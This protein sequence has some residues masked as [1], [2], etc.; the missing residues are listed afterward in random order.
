MDSLSSAAGI[1]KK[2]GGEESPARLSFQ[3]ARLLGDAAWLM[4]FSAKNLQAQ[5]M[6][7]NPRGK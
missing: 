7:W 3:T 5:S 6:F 4:K 2:V 1:I